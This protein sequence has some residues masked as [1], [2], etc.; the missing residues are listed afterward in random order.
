MQWRAQSKGE[1]PKFKPNGQERTDEE[2]DDQ[3]ETKYIYHT[4]LP[5]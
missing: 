2:E 3:K 1:R 5:E 4:D